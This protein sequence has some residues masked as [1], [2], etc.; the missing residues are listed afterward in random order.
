MSNESTYRTDAS[1]LKEKI[2][3]SDAN[4]AAVRDMLEKIFMEKGLKIDLWGCG[5][6]GSPVL[7][8]E[9]EDGTVYDR[10]EFKLNMRE[11]DD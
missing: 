2:D 1:I 11:E 3:M 7:I 10:S 4:D 6:C 8:I 9:F 5:C